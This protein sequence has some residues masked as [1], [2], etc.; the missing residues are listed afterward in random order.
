MIHTKANL[1]FWNKV[2]LNQDHS[3]FEDIS[4]IYLN[5]SIYNEM[6]NNNFEII[7]ENN[8]KN[9]LNA[10]ILP[11]YITDLNLKFLDFCNKD[12]ID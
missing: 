3:I 10:K 7:D 5:Q 4:F 9:I 8:L 1:K 12:Y 6:T 11:K 2:L